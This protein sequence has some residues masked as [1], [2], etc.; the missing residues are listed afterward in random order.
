MKQSK[1]SSVYD[2]EK[3]CL[4]KS[5]SESQYNHTLIFLALLYLLPRNVVKWNNSVTGNFQFHL[6]TPTLATILPYTQDTL[7]PCPHAFTISPVARVSDFPR[8]K[9][10]QANKSINWVE[11]VSLSDSHRFM[12]I[13]ASTHCRRCVLTRLQ[14]VDIAVSRARRG[15]KQMSRPRRQ[16]QKLERSERHGQTRKEK[17]LGAVIRAR[18]PVICDRAGLL[19]VT[20]T[21][22]QFYTRVQRRTTF[23]AR[24]VTHYQLQSLF[25]S[26]PSLGKG[27]HNGR[28]EE[29]RIFY[30][31]YLRA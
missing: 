4:G 15:A 21:P 6:S 22:P 26:Y 17:W 5:G 24:H 19:I 30:S 14:K 12:R 13:N 20:E 9:P 2:V 10:R 29:N 1:T 23:Y 3:R 28:A 25:R 18:R 8:Q 27:T 11:K 31:R 7:T 16:G